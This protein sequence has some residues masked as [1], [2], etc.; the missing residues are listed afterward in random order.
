L[1]YFAV[2]G[3]EEKTKTILFFC[4]FARGAVLIVVFFLSLAR[5]VGV[6]AIPVLGWTGLPLEESRVQSTDESSIRAS[7]LAVGSQANE[8]DSFM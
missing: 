6:D 7:S 4:D 3:W 2:C 8:Q 1:R 5:L